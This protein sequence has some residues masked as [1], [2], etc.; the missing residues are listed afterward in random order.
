MTGSAKLQVQLAASR[1]RD[2]RALSC[3]MGGSGTIATCSP[4]MPCSEDCSD[5]Y[6]DA[7]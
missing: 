7:R 1:R 2:Y 4:F 3:A 5:A 6:A